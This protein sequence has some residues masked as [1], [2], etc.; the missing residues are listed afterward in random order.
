MAIKENWLTKLFK[1]KAKKQTFNEALSMKG[2]EPNFTKFGSEIL[3]SDIVLSAL[4]MKCRFFGKLEPRHIRNDNGKITTIYDSSVAKILK[5]PNSFQTTY[6]FLTQA[7]FMREK[8]SNCYIYPDYYMTNGGQRF[9]TGLYIIIPS[10]KPTMLDDNGK[11]KLSFRIEGYSSEIIFNLDEIVVWKKD[12]EDNQ[13]IGGGNYNGNANS[14]LLTSLEAYHEIKQANAEAS[15]LGCLF[16]GIIKVNAYSSDNE[17]AQKIRDKFISDLRENKT[18]IAVLDQG[19]DYQ[20]IAR[21]LKTADAQTMKEIKENILIHTGVSVEMLMSKFTSQDKEAFYEN[22]IEPAS[23]SLG[24]ALTKVLFS[25]WQTSHGDQ[26][27]LYPHKVQLMATSEIVS[28]IQ[29]TISAGVFKIDEYR[30]MLGYAP[31][32]NGEGEARPRGFNNLDGSEKIDI[33]PKTEGGLE[34]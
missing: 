20:Q 19:A 2:Y 18:G 13:F 16:D 28:I 8:D 24:Q 15:K 5:K 34:Q 12:I 11:L 33:T 21:Q 4:K 10:E 17:K 22:F 14:D 29:S 3:N 7:Y 26:V 1:P 6:D 32:E 23:I 9:Y 31:L 30:E 27:I 25:D